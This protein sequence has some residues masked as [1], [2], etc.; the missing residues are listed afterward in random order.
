MVALQRCPSADVR[1]REI[2]S[3]AASLFSRRGFAGTTSAAL[4]KAC[5]VSEGLI[6][7]LFASKQS[8]YDAIIEHKLETWEDMKLEASASTPLE[9]VLTSLARHVFARVQED[10]DFVRLMRYAD[11][12]ESAFSQ[13][14]LEVRATSNLRSL[15]EHL[16][17]R[18][19]AG[20]LRSDIDPHLAGAAFLCQVWNYA[21]GVKVFGHVACFPPADD[22]DVIRTFVA[23][24]VRGVRR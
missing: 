1:R 18:I 19:A 8:L 15:G 17:A 23:I 11:L 5:G 13:R 7:K 20:E 16:S 24:F 3:A 9:D 14:F 2:V 4:A 6:Y 10:P 12:Q 22:A 21:I